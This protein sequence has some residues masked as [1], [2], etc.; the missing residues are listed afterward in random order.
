MSEVQA[1]GLQCPFL[2]AVGLPLE[3]PRSA[4]VHRARIVVGSRIK[5]QCDHERLI[6]VDE[7]RR[8][9]DGWSAADGTLALVVGQG[10]DDASLHGVYAAVERR[11]PCVVL[12]P[13]AP[14]RRASRRLTH[15]H[16]EPNIAITDPLAG[17]DG[18][19]SCALLLD[20]RSA[21]VS[22]HLTGRHIPGQMIAEAARQTAIAVTERFFLPPGRPVEVRFVTHE[23][24]V[25]YADFVLPLPIDIRCVPLKLR[26]ASSCSLR[27]SYEMHFTQLR[28]VAAVAQF[29][30]SVV[31]R[32]YFDSREKALLDALYGQLA[33]A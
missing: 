17:G 3:A 23:M 30:I 10:L 32:R 6:S 21:D 2:T 4:T 12:S 31:D 7:A 19:Y 33:A 27:V 18:S 11:G 24:S 26:R 15:K 20:E 5:S 13:S 29:S 14:P 1:M 16:V 28:Q 9:I 8:L 22:D 25:S